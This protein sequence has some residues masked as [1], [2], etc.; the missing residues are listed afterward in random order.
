MFVY[1]TFAN[2]M[3][4]EELFE[5]NEERIAKLASWRERKVLFIPLTKGEKGEENCPFALP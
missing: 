1:A 5:G 4:C 2:R 3:P